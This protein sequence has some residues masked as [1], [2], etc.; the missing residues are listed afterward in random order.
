MEA[1]AFTGAGPGG[2]HVRP[3][4]TGKPWDKYG[5]VTTVRVGSIVDTQ[6]RRRNRLTEVYTS[7]NPSY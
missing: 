2:A 7:G 6:R 1:L 4:V 3:I 5:V